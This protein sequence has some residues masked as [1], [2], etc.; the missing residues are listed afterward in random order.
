MAKFPSIGQTYKNLDD[1]IENFH[2]NLIVTLIYGVLIVTLCVFIAIQTINISDLHKSVQQE[3]NK[4]E[5]L[6]RKLLSQEKIIETLQ[7]EYRLLRTDTDI[8]FKY[9]N[10]EEPFYSEK[11]ENYE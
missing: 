5:Q 1:E 11:E 6:E 10:G 3:R 2:S 8:L 7:L 9:T 4:V